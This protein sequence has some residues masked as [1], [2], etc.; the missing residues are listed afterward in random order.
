VLTAAE[1]TPQPL[2]AVLR[3]L[4]ADPARLAAMGGAARALARPGAAAAIADQIEEL[5]ESR[6]R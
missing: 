3:E 4:I 5:A 1:F 2:A 6:R